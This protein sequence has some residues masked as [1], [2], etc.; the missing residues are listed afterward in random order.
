MCN[1][2]LLF[3]DIAAQFHLTSQDIKELIKFDPS[4]FEDFIF[5]DLMVVDNL[6]IK[7][8]D[9]GFIFAR[10]IAMALDPAYNQEENI[11]S[12]TV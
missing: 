9:K 7:V 8:L 11:Y 10:N 4:D 6:G 2:V 1:G 12:K 3:E 5:D